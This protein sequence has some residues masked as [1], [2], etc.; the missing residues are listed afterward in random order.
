ML[1]L[2]SSRSWLPRIVSAAVLAIA[3]LAAHAQS[4]TYPARPIRLVVPTPAG[5]ASDAAARLLG[6]SLAAALGQPVIVENKAGASGAIAVQAVMTSPADGYTLLWGQSS[7]AGLPMLHK[8]PPFR[9]MNEL[10]PIA[11][12]LH[13][14]YGVYINNQVPVKSFAELMAYGKA[15]P[16]K[17]TYATATLGEYMIGA[18]LFKTGAVKAVRVPYKGGAQLM[19]DLM[20]GLVQVNAGPLVV[21]MPLAKA[22]KIRLLATMLPERLPSLPEVPTLAELGV[23]TAGLPTW[24]GVF[25]PPNTPREVVN[26]LASEIALAMKSPALRTTIEQ[27]GSLLANPSP[28][29]L[30]A[31]VEGAT[32]AW[33][34]FVRDYDIPMEQ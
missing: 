15:N 2:T 12:V 8:N 20:S 3:P 24:N 31:D 4:I 34:N 1:L 6:Q 21:G 14:G 29:L 28:Q 7:M 22:G 27:Q 11:N 23:P 33:R 25:A 26:R 10:T 30:A 13:F 9:H 5:G 32:A 16:D 17:L 18:H 19:P